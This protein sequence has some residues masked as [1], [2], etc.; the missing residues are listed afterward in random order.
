[1]GLYGT[2]LKGAESAR[3]ADPENCDIRPRSFFYVDTGQGISP[4]AGVGGVAHAVR[5]NNLYD[6][7]QDALGLVKAH[8]GPNNWERAVMQA[9]FDGYLNNDPRRNQGFAVVLGAQHTNIPVKQIPK[10]GFSEVAAE[11]T[12]LKKGLM[13]KELAA[14]DLGQIPGARVANGSLSLP[15]S[16]RE[17]ANSEMAA[18]P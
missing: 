7:R 12:D 13:S 5:L 11:P 9:G 4:E 10:P 17:E 2:G 6:V 15:A 14:L 1:M 8:P 18:G 16:S 3:L